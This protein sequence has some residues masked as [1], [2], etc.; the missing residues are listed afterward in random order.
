MFRVGFFDVNANYA[1]G[2]SFMV[3]FIF[4]FWLAV[5]F[6]LGD[7]NILKMLGVTPLD[8][9][10][11]WRLAEDY[12]VE[13]VPK[14]LQWK[15]VSLLFQYIQIAQLKSYHLLEECPKMFRYR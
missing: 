4:A 15:G 2:L 13:Q 6:L 7:V 8:R 3:L 9:R 12:D 14:Y 11:I 5:D 1:Q 10:G